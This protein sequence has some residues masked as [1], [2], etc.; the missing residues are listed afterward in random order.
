MSTVDVNSSNL[1]L[2]KIFY[3]SKINLHRVILSIYVII[4]MFT[5]IFYRKTL[6]QESA[7]VEINLQQNLDL[8]IFKFFSDYGTLS[9]FFP[10]LIIFYMFYPLNISFTLF[11]VIIHATYWDN[12]FKILY[13]E[14]RPYWVFQELIPSCNVGFGNPSGH[15]MS[16]SAVYLSIW[17]IL[18][19]KIEFFEKRTL[20][21]ILLLIFFLMVIIMIIF[22]RLVL[23]AH[24]INQ[25][26][27][28]GLLGIAVY[29]AHFYVLE[30]HKL[31]AREFFEIF[32]SKRMKGIFAIFYSSLV[33]ISIL[34]YYCVPN[35][36]V[37][38]EYKEY[39]NKNCGK[40]EDFKKFND[41][42]LFNSLGIFALIGCHFGL[43]FFCN[44]M[45]KNNL[46]DKYEE[47]YIWNQTSWKNK[48]N[49]LMGFLLF[50]SPIL[51]FIIIPGRINLFFVYLF[52]IIL[53]YFIGC[54]GMFG[55]NLWFCVSNKY[56]NE[57]IVKE[58]VKDSFLDSL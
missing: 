44:F 45:E 29:L 41:D 35:T 50:G 18:I 16:S 58:E 4:V 47:I 51:L 30:M 3:Y 17:H 9:T 22:S 7:N 34:I 12:I 49:I 19:T 15:S 1:S 43:V 28:G 25:V 38:E 48:G 52:K 6:F 39:V 53:P 24:S 54:F 10:V 36:E 40:I 8:G 23:G 57:N 5:E 11:S 21:K 26:L 32:R 13:G 55:V 46:F 42:G 20:L 37:I 2:L 27:Y 33:F 31:K 56:C 14:P